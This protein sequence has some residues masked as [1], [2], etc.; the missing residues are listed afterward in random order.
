MLG[1][2]T[3]HCVYANITLPLL[4]GFHPGKNT[5]QRR[6]TGTIYSHHRDS[7]SLF[8]SKIKPI[9]NSVITISF[10]HLLKLHH[11]LARGW[12]GRKPEIDFLFLRLRFHNFHFFKCFYPTL[13]HRGLFNIRTET[14]NKLFLF[15]NLL[16]LVH[17]SFSLALNSGR[18]LLQIKTVVPLVTV[19]APHFQFNGS[20]GNTFQKRTIVGND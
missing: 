14:V 16:F 19:Q 12:R 2:V 4:K 3:N 20:F 5:R 11:F 7:V 10:G 6:F 17:I 8:D 18:T 15:L 1:K 9:K 13:Y